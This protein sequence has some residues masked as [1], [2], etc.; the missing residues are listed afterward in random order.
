MLARTPVRPSDEYAKEGN[1]AHDVLEAAVKNG[2][3]NAKTA[4]HDYSSVFMYDLNTLTNQFYFSIQVALDH[5]YSILDEYSQ[6]EPQVW[7]ESYVD[8]PLPSAPGEAG[9]YCDVCIYIEQLG[10]LFVIDYKHGA[11]VTVS[12]K[13]SK[14]IKQY[15]AGFL[16]EEHAKVDPAK[17]NEV[18]LTIVQPRG[19]HPDGLI[20]EHSVTPY[21]LYEYLLELD[22]KVQACEREDAPL[23]P[24]E[25]QCMFCDARTLCPA[26]E[27]QALQGA[28][29]TFSQ[30]RDFTPDTL[31][32]P[33]AMDMDRLGLIRYHAPQ[34]RKWLKDVDD[35]CEELARGGHHVPGAKLVQTQARRKYYGEDRHVARKL[36]A[37]IGERYSEEAVA[38]YDKVMHDHPVL[39]RMFS[40]RLVPVT[41]A[42]KLVVETY[43]S[44]VGR[45]RKK[46]AAEEGKQAFAFLTLKQHSGS[47]V[48]VDEDDPRPAVNKAQNSF[49]N[50]AALLPPPPNSQEN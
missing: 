34:L 18:I 13:D 25:T 1:D 9:G 40:H 6:Y 16:Y 19:Q 43:K 27:A 22:D 24:G 23:N 30:I 46:K 8:P 7:V 49:K 39:Q 38:A 31:P 15:G 32:S 47:T 3:R 35:H 11:G 48:L 17:V 5:I 2:V 37:L 12:A 20:R 33:G 26:R 29:A 50:V 21:E 42:E 28:V 4:H 14:Q 44:R 45:G 10:L 36:A 41:E